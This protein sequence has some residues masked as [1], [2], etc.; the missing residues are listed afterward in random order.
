MHRFGE[1]DFHLT[2]FLSFALPL[3]SSVCSRQSAFPYTSCTVH[4]PRPYRW[5]MHVVVA[6]VLC[7]GSTPGP[8]QFTGAAVAIYI[9]MPPS[10]LPLFPEIPGLIFPLREGGGR[11]RPITFPDR[12]AITLV[13]CH[14]HWRFG[15]K[16]TCDSFDDDVAQIIGTVVGTFPTH[17]RT[18]AMCIIKVFYTRFKLIT[19]IPFYSLSGV[20]TSTALPLPPSDTG[21]PTW[22]FSWCWP[23][24]FLTLTPCAWS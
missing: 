18:N 10:P 1:D 24:R 2:P 20:V 8:D 7:L 6:Y 3:F 23:P 12:H 5:S 15:R 22:T 9:L 13:P 4:T 16:G 11:D 14:R 17:T 19:V 21:Q